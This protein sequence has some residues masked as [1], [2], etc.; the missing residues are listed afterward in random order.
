MN[1]RSPLAQLLIFVGVLV[2][3]NVVA[4]LLGLGFRVSIIG[5][6]I[7]SIVVSA[8]MNRVMRR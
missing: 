1:R 3:I 2:T 8:I 5:S 7:L 4:Q 6:I